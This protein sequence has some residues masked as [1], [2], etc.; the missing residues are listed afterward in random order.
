MIAHQLNDVVYQYATAL[1]YELTNHFMFSD[2]DYAVRCV[3][4]HK[5]ALAAGETIPAQRDFV[6]SLMAADE[7]GDK[8][9][10]VRKLHGYAVYV[11]Y[12]SVTYTE[13]DSRQLIKNYLLRTRLDPHF[14]IYHGSKLS[15]SSL[16]ASPR[17]STTMRQ[18]AGDM[19]AEDNSSPPETDGGGGGG[20]LKPLNNTGTGNYDI[21]DL[22]D[23][24]GGGGD[25]VNIW[26]NGNVDDEQ[27]YYHRDKRQQNSHHQ[28][29]GAA[30]NDDMVEEDENMLEELDDKQ[31]V[32][33]IGTMEAEHWQLKEQVVIVI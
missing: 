1:E 9:P 12:R 22:D 8:R 11:G 5:I 19:I 16:A 3:P 31:L 17:K 28:P 14:G 20:G 21:E 10:P 33:R 23:G 4:S 18:I 2:T 32:T 27:D 6:A 13:Q 26:Q 29:T 24:V 15:T 30:D 25:D 7:S